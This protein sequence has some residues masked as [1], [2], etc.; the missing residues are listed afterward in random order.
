MN[1]WEI[2]A[3]GSGG[4]SGCRSILTQKKRSIRRIEFTTSIHAGSCFMIM[5]EIQIKQAL[6][7]DRAQPNSPVIMTDSL[8]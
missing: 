7:F 1:R 2:M 5:P 8:N 6:V 4:L 3:I